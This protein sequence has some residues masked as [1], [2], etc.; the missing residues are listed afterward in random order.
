MTKSA[1]ASSCVGRW[2]AT[3]GACNSSESIAEALFVEE[4]MRACGVI[5]FDANS[6]P[7]LHNAGRAPDAIIHVF[8]IRNN[9]PNTSITD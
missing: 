4:T 5:A 6:T 2:N 9:L 3:E 1:S 7:C 8:E